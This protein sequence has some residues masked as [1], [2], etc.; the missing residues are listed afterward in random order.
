M[1]FFFNVY[2]QMFL[3]ELR[4]IYRI[5]PSVP[6]PSKAAQ[7]LLPTRNEVLQAHLAT[8]SPPHVLGRSRENKDS[9]RSHSSEGSPRMRVPFPSPQDGSQ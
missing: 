7:K 2:L 5:K 3:P 9:A 8:W 4:I 1:T 6:I